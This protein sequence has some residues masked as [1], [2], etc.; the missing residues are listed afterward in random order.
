MVCIVEPEMGKSLP[1][2]ENERCELAELEQQFI[3][4]DPKFAKALAAPL[5]TS[6]KSFRRQLV[7]GSL[8]IAAGRIEESV[9]PVRLRF[10]HSQAIARKPAPW[11]GFGP[12]VV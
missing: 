8:L 12:G 3:A 2:S 10:R 11:P 5:E 6:A 4:D 7:I 9:G 1:L